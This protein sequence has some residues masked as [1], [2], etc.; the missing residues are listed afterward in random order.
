METNQNKVAVVT[1]GGSGIGF[2]IAEK[3]V[4]HNITTIIVG[5]DEQKL[6]NAKINLG[7][8]CFTM[9]CDLNDLNSI[10][11][12][13]QKIEK[14]LKNRRKGK[15]VRFVYDREMDPALLEYAGRDAFKVRIFPIE[16]NARKHVKLQ[17]TQL[18]KSDGGSITLDLFGRFT[19]P[20][21]RGCFVRW[22][23]TK[24][25]MATAKSPIS[26]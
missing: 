24:Q 20:D 3:F 21:G 1:G 5:R 10:P 19:F 15:P 8:L 2:A 17:Y 26:G 12:L 16:P 7:E 23:P 14:G 6:S 13:I 11:S 25:S 4:E 18:L 22:L 9:Q